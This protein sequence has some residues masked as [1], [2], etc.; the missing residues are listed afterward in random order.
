MSSNHPMVQVFEEDKVEVHKIL[1]KSGG[2]HVIRGVDER[3]NEDGS[4]IP[5]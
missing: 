1:R 5:S 3:Q 4:T 2:K